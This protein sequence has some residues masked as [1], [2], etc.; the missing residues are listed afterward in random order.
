MSESSQSRSSSH[1]NTGS[2]LDLGSSF[3][4][5]VNYGTEMTTLQNES[6]L[7]LE[8]MFYNKALLKF[9]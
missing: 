9:F 6:D 5:F 2:E 3:A 1:V 4:S 8:V 7:R